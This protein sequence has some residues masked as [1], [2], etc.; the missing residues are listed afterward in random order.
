MAVTLTES[1]SGSH[2]SPPPVHAEA[3]AVFCSS[4]LV[5]SKTPLLL[6]LPSILFKRSFAAL[7]STSK[8]FLFVI[9]WIRKAVSNK[10][11]TTQGSEH[12][13]VYK[14]V[15]IYIV[16][17]LLPKVCQRWEISA[18]Q[19][20]SQSQ[21]K[22]RDLFRLPLTTLTTTNTNDASTE[23]N[24]E[25]ADSCLKHKQGTWVHT[26]HTQSSKV[27]K[28][29]VRLRHSSMSWHRFACEAADLWPNTKS[30]SC[31]L[32]KNSGFTT[33]IVIKVKLLQGPNHLSK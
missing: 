2:R 16:A 1:R 22:A 31:L 19:L 8:A 20:W 14:Y 17:D 25:N 18:E 7:F 26:D 11:G 29:R 27:T 15:Y 12:V 30:G 3:A 4:A 10:V 5:I 9:S 6:A 33:T 13:Y 32:F 28:A 23:K 21:P 24:P